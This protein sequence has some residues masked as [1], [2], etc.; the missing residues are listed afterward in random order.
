MDLPYYSF[1]ENDLVHLSST[2]CPKLESWSGCDMR[3]TERE[4]DILYS[5]VMAIDPMARIARADKFA[6]YCRQNL[7]VIGV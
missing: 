1:D 7:P 5:S 2:L 3:I 6:V 4:K